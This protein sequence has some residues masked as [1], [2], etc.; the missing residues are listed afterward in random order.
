M[1]NVAEVIPVEKRIEVKVVAA[2][3][4]IGEFGPGLV[5]QI[6]GIR[7]HVHGYQ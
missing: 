3:G 5:T 4:D 7:Y 2:K 6:Q 1:L